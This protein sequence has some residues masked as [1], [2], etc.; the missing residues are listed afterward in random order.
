MRLKYG[1][2]MFGDL[3]LEI[4]LIVFVSISLVYNCLVAKIIFNVHVLAFYSSI[5]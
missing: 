1:L 4:A 5:M 2:I 3:L